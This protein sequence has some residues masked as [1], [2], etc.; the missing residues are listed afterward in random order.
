VKTKWL[1][2]EILAA[3]VLWCT[4]LKTTAIADDPCSSDPCQNGGS[5]TQLDEGGYN[6]VCWM[7]FTG[8]NCEVG[9]LINAKNSVQVDYQQV[10]I[11]SRSDL[12]KFT[13][14]VLFSVVLSCVYTSTT[15]YS[16]GA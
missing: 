4:S 3:S 7:D 12:T 13:K 11:S 10:L 2:A 9:E 6:C 14:L 1:C 8:A 5:C 16:S 15:L